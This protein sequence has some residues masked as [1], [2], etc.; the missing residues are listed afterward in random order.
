MIAI[1]A[2][3]RTLPKIHTLKALE[4][5]PWTDEIKRVISGGAQGPDTHGAAWA[6]EHNIPVHF[7]YPQYHVYGK[8]APLIRNVEMAKKGEALLL[9]WDNLSTGSK[10]MYEEALKRNLKI[11][12]YHVTYGVRSDI[13]DG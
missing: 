10:H 11:F 1:I 2:G 5:C 3:T 12:V 8:R 7:C 6:I 4:A 9:V 13:G